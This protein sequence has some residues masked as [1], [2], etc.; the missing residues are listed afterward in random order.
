[1]QPSIETLRGFEAFTRVI[2]R[3]KKYEE[4][5]IKAFVFSLPS[6]QTSIRVG[7]AVA[8]GLK[9]ATLRNRVKRLMRESFRL[10]KESL[11]R[12]ISSITAIE[13]VFL[14]NDK[15]PI[16]KNRSQFEYINRAIAG[17]CSSI[18]VILTE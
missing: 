2:T 11:M 17:L 10:N 18:K 4:K 14:Y 8:K 9:K 3:G 5:P 13:I 6:K 7:F 16:F 1:M 12:R 15:G